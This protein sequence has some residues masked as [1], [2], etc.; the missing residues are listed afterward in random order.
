MKWELATV[1][2]VAYLKDGPFIENVEPVD[3]IKRELEKANF[4]V[5]V[6]GD[7]LLKPVV[8]PSSDI[9][10]T[11]KYKR[12]VEYEIYPLDYADNDLAF[13]GYIFSQASAIMPADLRGASFGSIM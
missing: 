11:R 7:Q 9:K 8:L 6:N 12:G 1:S 3:H 4:K 13:R 5:F 2:P 10:Y